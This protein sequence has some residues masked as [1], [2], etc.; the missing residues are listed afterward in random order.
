MTTVL[1][2]LAVLVTLKWDATGCPGGF[3]V[4][5]GTPLPGQTKS[6]VMLRVV[7]QGSQMPA[8]QCST[9]LDLPNGSYVLA[10]WSGQSPTTGIMQE[11]NRCSVSVY[12]DKPWTTD[13]PDTI[14]PVPSPPQNLRIVSVT[15]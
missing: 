4:A 1:A 11:T 15:Q 2:L 13:C 9:Q 5:Q 12:P 8:G 3:M 6:Q 14:T 7:K 10:L